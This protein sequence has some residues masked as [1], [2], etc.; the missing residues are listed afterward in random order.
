MSSNREPLSLE[1]LEAECGAALPAKEVLSV[2][3][4]DLNVDI[5]LALAL[6]A[7]IDLGVAGNLNVALPVNGGVSASALSVLSSAGAMSTQGVLL[8]QLITGEAVA[9]GHQ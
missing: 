8:D 6:A 9:E 5:D 1:E 2:P 3:L 4:L 7:P